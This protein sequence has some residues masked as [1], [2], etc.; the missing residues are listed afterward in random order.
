MT[1]ADSVRCVVGMIQLTAQ[2]GAFDSKSL[3]RYKPLVM[4][5]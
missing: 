3:F 1:I 5:Q 4:S 2:P